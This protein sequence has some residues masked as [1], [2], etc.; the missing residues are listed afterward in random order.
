MA[1]D[2]K[3]THVHILLKS[4]LTN[5]WEFFFLYNFVAKKSFKHSKKIFWRKVKKQTNKNVKNKKV[6]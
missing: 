2:Y 4:A 5:V 1:L 6:T 3:Y